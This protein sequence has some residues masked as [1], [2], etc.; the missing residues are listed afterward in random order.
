MSAGPTQILLDRR[1]AVRPEALT[2]K[3]HHRGGPAL[4]VVKDRD[5]GRS[6]GFGFV[7]MGPANE[8][9]AAIAQLDGSML[10]GRSL[11]VNEAEERQNNLGGSGGG[12]RSGGGSAGKLRR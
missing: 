5:S 9:T 1:V 8:A 4:H 6:R 10:D 12:G 11:R 2:I 7:T 3:R